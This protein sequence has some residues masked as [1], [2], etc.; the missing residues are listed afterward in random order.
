[1]SFYEDDMDTFFSDFTD[2]AEFTAGANIGKVIP[3]IFDEEAKD[4]SSPAGVVT[5]TGP[6]IR[7]KTSDVA[8]Y[9]IKKGDTLSINGKT[10][11]ITSPARI[12]GPGI[13]VFKLQGA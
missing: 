1:M 3:V 6:E 4:Y 13:K 7:V 2:D 8:L 11:T 5:A 10:W 12:D 9:T